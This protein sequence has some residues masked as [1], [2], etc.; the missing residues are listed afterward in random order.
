MDQRIPEAIRPLL[1]D[2]LQ[3]LSNGLPDL[4]EAVYLHGS[5]ALGAFNDRLSDIDFITVLH[6]CPTANEIQH[7]QA[8]HQTLTTK[9]PQWTLDGSYLQGHD[10][11]Q[12]PDAVTPYPYVAEGIVHS[13]GYRDLNLVTWWVLKHHGIAVLGLSPQTL[14][15]RVSWDELVV[16]MHGNLNSYWRSWTR[17]PTRWVQLLTDYGIQW[18]VLGI[19]RLW[20]TFREN[21]ITSKTDAGRYALVHLPSCWHPLIQ[22]AINLRD[23][24]Q[25]RIYR[26][27]LYRAYIA[28]Q[29]LNDM[30]KQCNEQFNM[31]SN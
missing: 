29:F 8:I 16:R 24:P 2:Y 14:S 27:R 31:K 10:L 30:I 26:F 15:F 21:D 4:A 19:L 17:T 1:Q 11:G 7:L 9:Y 28:V 6:H 5:I 25:E 20:Y 23:S 18:A 13:Q 3:L 22:E 12:L